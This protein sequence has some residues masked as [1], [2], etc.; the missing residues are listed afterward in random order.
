MGTCSMV[1]G[2]L[3]A[4]ITAARQVDIVCAPKGFLRFSRLPP[5]ASPRALFYSGSL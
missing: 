5:H 3:C 2:L 4:V 1:K